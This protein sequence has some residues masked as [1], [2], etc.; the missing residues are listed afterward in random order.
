MAL[1]AFPI[2]AID[3]IDAF[4]NI[5]FSKM[6]VVGLWYFWKHWL[7]NDEF[8]DKIQSPKEHTNLP[9]I[10]NREELALLF[11]EHILPKVL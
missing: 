4:Y 7:D 10:M 2:V 3:K 6:Y 11:A 9:K 8:V 5:G 1:C